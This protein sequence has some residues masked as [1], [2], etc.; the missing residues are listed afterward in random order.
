MSF[1]K[2]NADIRALIL[3]VR[4]N[5]QE[6]FGLLLERYK[7]LIEASV[8]R[9]SA[10]EAFATYRDDLRQEAS[11]VFYNSILAYDLEQSEVEF[12][13]FAKVCIH[14]ALV[15]QLRSL[16]KHSAEM[17]MEPSENISFVQV[18]DDPLTKIL[19][20][21]RLK[22]IYAVIRK[23]LS[24]LEYTVWQMYVAGRSSAD[25]ASAMKTDKR[26]VDNAIY[27]IR[28]KLRALLK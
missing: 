10:D 3:R 15:S 23:N 4:N 6:A 8:N 7:P 9:F 21:E 24:D 12:G 25:I 17:V 20:Q 13:L 26:S 19:E 28:K 18:S 27:R 22:S 16:K 5:D 1:D 2:N 14:N 11:V